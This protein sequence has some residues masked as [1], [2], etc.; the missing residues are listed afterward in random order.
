MRD[1]LY[2]LESISLLSPLV[3]DPLDLFVRDHARFNDF[4]NHNPL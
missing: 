1:E 2:A 4:I 3:Q